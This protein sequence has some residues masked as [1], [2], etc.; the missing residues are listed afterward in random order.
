MMFGFHSSLGNNPFLIMKINSFET[1]FAGMLEWEKDILDDIFPIFRK[2][3][4][5]IDISTNPKFEDIVI[6]NKDVRAILNDEG[7]L[8]F[9]YSF[10]DKDTLIMINNETTLQEIFRRLRTSKLERSS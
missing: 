5:K 10:A 7:G 1:A 2:E 8:E 4:S 6:S 9:A 3:V